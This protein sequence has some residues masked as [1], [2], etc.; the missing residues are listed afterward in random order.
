[1]V[2]QITYFFYFFF[3]KSGPKKNYLPSKLFLFLIM[4]LGKFG[5]TKLKWER[6]RE[7]EIK[8]EEINKRG[9]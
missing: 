5:T 4:R 9:K 1:M 7:R 2:L 6:E 3:L 8:K